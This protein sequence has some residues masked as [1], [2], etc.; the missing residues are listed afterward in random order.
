MYDPD[1]NRYDSML[2]DVPMM[3]PVREYNPAHVMSYAYFDT[4]LIEKLPEG[5]VIRCFAPCPD[6]LAGRPC[7]C[8]ERIKHE[9]AVEMYEQAR[10]QLAKPHSG[11][12]HTCPNGIGKPRYCETCRGSVL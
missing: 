7:P 3:R 6:Q 8:T 4:K 11:N 5:W 10:E 2:G 1:V 9:V 12:P